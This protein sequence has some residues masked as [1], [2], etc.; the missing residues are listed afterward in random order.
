M[1]FINQAI[2]GV[3]NFFGGASTPQVAEL[4]R[5]SRVASAS[6]ALTYFDGNAPAAL[7]VKAGQPDDNIHINYASVIV[8]KKVAF[9]FG[10]PLKISV[11]TDDDKTG[12]EYLSSVWSEEQRA[13]DFVDMATEGAH[14]GDVFLKISI[15]PDGSPRVT[16]GDPNLLSAECDPHDVSRV[17]VYRCQYKIP[18]PAGKPVLYKEET[19]PAADGKT[20]LIREYHSNDEGRTFIP[21]NEGVTWNYPFAPI[22]HSKNLPKSKSFNGRP[23]LRPDVLRL[24]S[25]IARLDSMCSKTVRV[26]SSP[27]PYARGLKKQDLEWGTDGMLFLGTGTQGIEAQVGLLEMKG[28]LVGALALRK[29]LRE[30]LAEVSKTPEIATGKVESLGQISG[31][32][33][34]ILYS[35]LIDE[36]KI[37]RRLIGRLIKD[38]CVALL[39]IGGKGKLT[40]VL[41]WADPLPV[42]EKGQIEAAEGKKR[43]GISEQTIHSELG[44]DAKVERAQREFDSTDAATKMLDAFDRGAGADLAN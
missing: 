15:Q 39:V 29:V 42:D 28:D 22:F 2:S 20:W 26:H 9:L 11:G 43:L 3:K 23:D 32:A 7:T 38:V 18:G 16:V 4:E 10:E 41:V 44:Y 25:A 30:G 14:S 21:V 35:P 8:D 40:V 31:V 33:L 37:K 27:K 13:E 36:T 19:T 24:I 12:E 34:R 17:V 1:S 5:I 6:Q